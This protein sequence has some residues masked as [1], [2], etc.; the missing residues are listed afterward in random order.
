MSTRKPSLLPGLILIIIGAVLLVNKLTS[1]Y[2]GWD[3]IYP[4]ILIIIGILIFKAVL[5]KR[6]KGG[7]FFGTLLFLLGS[8]FLLR[9]YDFI[10]YRYVREVWPIIL[11][12]LGLSFLSV[13]MFYPKDW[14]SLIPG[15]MFL[16]IG[17][18]I[19]LKRLDLIYFDLG[20]IIS[21]YWPV[22]LIIIGGAIVFGA[23]KK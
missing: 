2:V 16:F 4:I 3:E 7:I 9:N 11:M 13:S 5:K 22:T 17:G 19:Y 1:Y 12:I 15:A 21:D 23:L 18:I 10:S 14:V 8:Y 20:E 6:D